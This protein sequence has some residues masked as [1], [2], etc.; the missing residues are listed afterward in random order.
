[1][2]RGVE[3]R[4]S[5]WTLG[6]PRA[7]GISGACVRLPHREAAELARLTRTR[8]A[9][10]LDAASANCGAHDE[11]GGALA[12]ASVRNGGTV[13]ARKEL[14]MTNPHGPN[15]HGP[16]RVGVGGPVGSGK[17]ALMDALC[18]KLARPLRDRRHHQRHLH[19]MGRRI[20][21]ALGRAG[22]RSHRR[23]RN[24]RLPAHRDPRGRLDQSR[25]GRRH[26]GEIS[27][28]RSGADRIRR[29]QSGRDVFAGA[30]RSDAS[31]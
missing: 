3:A 7:L 19:Q 20:S 2:S 1:M 23:R 14:P 5:G 13:E 21:G 22:R 25:R 4:G 28:S 31:T 24:R 18:K 8:V 11:G 29:R 10:A 12:C 6:V 30:C 17:T 26:A 16:L 27:R 15:P 9:G